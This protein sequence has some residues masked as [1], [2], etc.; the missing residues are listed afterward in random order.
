M[1]NSSKAHLGNK[2]V[3]LDHLRAIAITAVFLYH[4]RLFKHPQWVDDLFSFGWVGVDLFF[5]LSG[6][7]IA[8]QLFT[9]LRKNE[10]IPV[11]E[12]VIKRFFRIIPPFLVVL[13]LYWLFPSLQEKKK[14]R[15]WSSRW[16]L[17]GSISPLQSTL[18]WI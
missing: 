11:N 17:S 14:S 18:I 13:S 4:Y 2:Y 16:R 8:G 5:V 7:L 1:V 3:G 6:F 15:A 9:T 12:F 10:P